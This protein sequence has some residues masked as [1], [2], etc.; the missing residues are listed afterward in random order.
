VSRYERLQL[1]NQALDLSAVWVV[2]PLMSARLSKQFPP[3]FKSVFVHG[4]AAWH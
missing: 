2:Y 3:E 4:M 1:G